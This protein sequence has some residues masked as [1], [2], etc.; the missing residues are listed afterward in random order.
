MKSAEQ[1]SVSWRHDAVPFEEARP[2][3]LGE[4]TMTA[5]SRDADVLRALNKIEAAFTELETVLKKYR[6]VGLADLMRRS[7]E[8]YRSLLYVETSKELER[9]MALLQA[10]QHLVEMMMRTQ[11]D[12]VRNVR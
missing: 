11:R 7:P 3:M 8:F 2:V 10:Q 5:P 9:R 1:V 4:V 6:E 12:M